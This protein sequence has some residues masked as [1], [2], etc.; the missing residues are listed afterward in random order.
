MKRLAA[1]L[2]CILMMTV[3]AF[4]EIEWPANMTA[5]Q[6][7]LQR[8]VACVN[9]ALEGSGVID[10]RYEMYSTFASLGMNGA[11]MPEDPFAQFTLPAEM[12]FVMNAEGMESLQLR[13]PVSIYYTEDAS[14]MRVLQ[15]NAADVEAF[16]NTAAAC[17]HASSPTAVS[18]EHARTITQAYA[19]SI[20]AAPSTSFGEEVVT[21][22]GSQPRAYFAYF[23]NQFRDN[24]YSWIQMTLVFPHPGSQDAPIVVPIS[25]PAPET[26]EDQVYLA[27]D[28]YNHLEVFATPTPEPDS[29]AME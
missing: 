5:G 21:I 22:Q 26:D 14:G 2:F 29:A 18:M 19:T 1:L 8:Y 4:A 28:N 7:Q 25:T 11:E 9:E 6:Q 17:L 13:M 15:L 27:D 12:Y 3:V 10:M 23:P 24:A 16:A 20:L